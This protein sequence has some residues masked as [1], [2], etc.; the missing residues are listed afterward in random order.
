MST[1]YIVA[2]WK[3]IYT[4]MPPTLESY[5]NTKAAFEIAS[6]RRPKLSQIEAGAEY[7]VR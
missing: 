4:A 5:V 7:S 2:R 6:C 1:A 3:A